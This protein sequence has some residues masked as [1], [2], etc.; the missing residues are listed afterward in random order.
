MNHTLNETGTPGQS[1]QP[2][3]LDDFDPGCEVMRRNIT[4]ILMLAFLLI[5]LIAK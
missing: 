2:M 1:D 3:D 4:S 5:Y